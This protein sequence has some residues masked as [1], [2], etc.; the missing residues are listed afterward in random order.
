LEPRK[1]G[2]NPLVEDISKW[3]SLS[4]IRRIHP[5]FYILAGVLVMCAVAGGNLI[6]D[7][8]GPPEKL[9]QHNREVLTNIGLSLVG[10]IGLIGLGIWR[11]AKRSKP[12]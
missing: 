10:G 7:Y 5:A 6:G 8:I 1:S 4:L 3:T 2:N 11:Q 9:E 12:L